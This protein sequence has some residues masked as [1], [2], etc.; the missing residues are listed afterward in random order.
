MSLKNI[1][2]GSVPSQCQRRDPRC[3]VSRHEASFNRCREIGRRLGAD[4]VVN[5]NEHNPVEFVNTL[6]RDRGAD[7]VME[8]SGAPQALDQA[9]HMTSRGGRICLAAFAQERVL[10]D[11]RHIVANNI[12]VFGIRGEGRSA[13]FTVTFPVREVSPV[14]AAQNAS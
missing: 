9:V 3:R 12:Y 1:D 14:I 8:C 6:T 13:T 2:V 5:V 11:V 10:V 4:F 7:Y